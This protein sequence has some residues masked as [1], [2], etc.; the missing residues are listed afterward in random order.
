MFQRVLIIN[1]KLQLTGSYLEW[2]VFNKDGEAVSFDYRGQA[3]VEGER[4]AIEVGLHVYDYT[5]SKTP[6]AE[7]TERQNGWDHARSQKIRREPLKATSNF[8]Q[9]WAECWRYRKGTA[10]SLY[11]FQDFSYVSR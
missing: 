1:G 6:T 3:F 8:Y 7:S 10:D 2:Q 11:A 9:A 4:L 5:I